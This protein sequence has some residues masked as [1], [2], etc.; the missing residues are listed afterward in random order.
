MLFIVK[1]PCDRVVNFLVNQ[2]IV[3]Q[4]IR[5]LA[6]GS[7]NFF[8]RYWMLVMNNMNHDGREERVNQ[9]APLPKDLGR[10]ADKLCESAL[11]DA[12]AQ[13]HPLLRS[14]DLYRLGQRMEFVK[15]FKLALERRIAQNL[16]VWQPDVQAVFQYEESWMESRNSWD[17]SIHLLVKVPRLSSAVKL[18]GKA[19]DSSLVRHL[20]QLGWARFQKRQTV[21]EVQQ[22]TPD[23]LRHGVGYGGMFFAVHSM[24]LKVWPQRRR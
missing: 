8:K 6:K 15:A 20:K 10:I 1:A 23:E 24:P 5:N 14:A 11:E 2:N 4:T 7:V 12:K 22:V 3:D 19:L 17:G 16:A 21:L 9:K 18:M 13:L